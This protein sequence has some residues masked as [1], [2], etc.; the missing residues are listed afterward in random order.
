[1]GRQVVDLEVRREGSAPWGLRLVG[2]ADVAAVLKV[3]KV[4]GINTAAGRAGVAAGDVL[5]EVEGQLVTMMTHPQV[6]GLIR[7]VRGATLR[8]RVERGDHIVPNMQECFPIKTE[9]DYNEMT[10]EERLAYYQ[11]AMKRGLESR[12]VPPFFTCIGKMKV[13]TPKYNSPEGMY[14]EGTM[15]EMVSGTSGLD[16]SKLDP[17]GPAYQKMQR[18]KKFN[19]KRSS[20]LMVLNAQLAGDFAVS[21]GEVREARQDY[22]EEGRRI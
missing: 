18:T 12:L 1:M 15:D 11:E 16:E 14:S 7:G 17:E 3:E 8:L 21:T 4:L 10:E 19:P 5:V 2:G 13:K 6:C 20:V 9:A 22:S